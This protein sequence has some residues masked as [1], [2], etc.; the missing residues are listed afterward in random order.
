MFSSIPEGGKLF[1]EENRILLLIRKRLSGV[2]FHLGRGTDTVL[3]FPG[4]N[5]TPLMGGR[6]HKGAPALAPCPVYLHR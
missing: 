5:T 4:L 2:L 6:R 1:A 3:S